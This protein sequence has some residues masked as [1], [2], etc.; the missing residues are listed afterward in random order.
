[1][2]GKQGNSVKNDAEV[3][4]WTDGACSGNPGPGGWGA[5]LRFGAHE[6]T[7]SGGEPETTNNRMEMQAVIEGLNALRRSCSVHV[8][9][10][11]TYV[12]KG[13]TEWISGWRKRGWK[14]AAGKPVKNADLWRNLEAATERH[15]VAWTWVK[16]HAGHVENERAD[17]LARHAIEAYRD[18][19]N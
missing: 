3:L 11:S 9:T 6:K 1:M 10:D 7:L 14:T 13:M 5:L 2:A 4:M 12:L 8:Y 17:E 18:K 15:T 16:G 19:N